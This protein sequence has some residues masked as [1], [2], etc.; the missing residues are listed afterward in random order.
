VATVLAELAEK[1]EPEA[2]RKLAQHAGVSDV[3]R[4]GYVLDLV[5]SHQ[6]P[7]LLQSWLQSQRLRPVR[8]AAE[9]AKGRSAPDP[10]WRGIPNVRIELDQ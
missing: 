4:L 8:L 3:Q 5:D 1:L 2:L 10:K 9:R 7:A 6:R